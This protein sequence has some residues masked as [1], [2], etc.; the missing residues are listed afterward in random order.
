[1]AYIVR[2][3]GGALTAGEVMKYVAEQVSTFIF[4]QVGCEIRDEKIQLNGFSHSCTTSIIRLL[5]C[6]DDNLRKELT[7]VVK[8]LCGRWHH[9]KRFGRLLSLTL[10]QSQLLA[11]QNDANLLSSHVFDQDCSVG[12]NRLTVLFVENNFVEL[13]A[14]AQSTGILPSLKFACIYLCPFNST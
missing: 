14:L 9:I 6:G 11:R 13:T 5:L 1:M 7:Q 8:I 10:F 2:E 3:P 4:I 12:I